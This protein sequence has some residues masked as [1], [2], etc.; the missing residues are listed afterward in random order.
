[1]GLD[2]LVTTKDS[3]GAVLSVQHSVAV[4]SQYFA[5]QNVPGVPH[6]SISRTAHSPSEASARPSPR[7]SIN[8]PKLNAPH[9]W[10]ILNMVNLIGSCS[11]TAT[12]PH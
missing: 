1:M 8:S 7:V 4:A 11:K 12:W 6:R 9:T 3:T 2:E 10:Q 5:M